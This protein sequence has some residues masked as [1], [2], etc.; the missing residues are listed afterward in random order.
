[1]IHHVYFWLKS[2]HQSEANRAAFER[3]LE[4]LTTIPEAKYAQIATPAKTP[5]REEVM[6]QSWDYAL[7]IPFGSVSDHNTYQ[8]HPI[9]EEFVT[10]F[11][12]LWAKVEVRDLE[13][14]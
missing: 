5:L 9:H 7:A 4:S 12:Y 6:D 2:E 3:G 13:T 10:A 1:M 8:A 11:S 14:I